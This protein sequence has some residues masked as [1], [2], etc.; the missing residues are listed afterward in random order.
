MQ[1]WGLHVVKMSNMIRI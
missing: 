1:D